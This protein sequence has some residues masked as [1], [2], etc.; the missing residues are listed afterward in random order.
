MIPINIII[1]TYLMFTFIIIHQIIRQNKT[2]KRLDDTHFLLAYYVNKFGSVDPEEI[3]ES[4]EN[5]SK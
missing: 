2:D 3:L 1:I 5:E 4:I